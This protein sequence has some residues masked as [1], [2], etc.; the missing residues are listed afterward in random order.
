[1]GER[2]DSAVFRLVIAPLETDQ[3]LRCRGYEISISTNVGRVPK[4]VNWNKSALIIRDW[5]RDVLP[6]LAEGTFRYVVP[7][8]S[9]PFEITI[10]KIQ[11]D[12]LD[13]NGELFVMRNAPH[14]TLEEVIKTALQNKLPKL[15]QTHS[16][17][18]I[19]LLERADILGGYFRFKEALDRLLPS[20]E[21]SL[22]PTEIWMVNSAGW[23]M[24]GS[25]MFYDLWPSYFQHKIHRKLPY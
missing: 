15:S 17:V 21:E 25:L 12:L 8:L 5:L 7:G 3:T 16:D 24:H 6:P 22:R 19:L 23:K 20:L 9:F 1:V 13:S 14:D 11:D 4:G 2:E 10:E 18:K